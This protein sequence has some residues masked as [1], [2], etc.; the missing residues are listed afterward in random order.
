MNFVKILNLPQLG[1]ITNS[2]FLVIARDGFVGGTFKTTLG[3]ILNSITVQSSPTINLYYDSNIPLLSADFKF[4]NTANTPTINLRYDTVLNVLTASINNINTLNTPTVSL[5]YDTVLNSLTAAL[6]PPISIQ[7][8]GTGITTSPNA[9]TLLIGNGA[10]YTLY[11][12]SDG[13]KIAGSNFQVAIEPGGGLGFNSNGE[14]KIEDKVTFIDSNTEIKIYIPTNT[15]MTTVPAGNVSPNTP[16]KYVTDSL[17]TGLTAM[18]LPYY[19]NSVVLVN[20]RIKN[21]LVPGT[22]FFWSWP[23]AAPTAPATK[24]VNILF[25]NETGSTDNVGADSNYFSGVI[26]PFNPDSLSTLRHRNDIVNTRNAL[27]NSN[28]R[29]VIIQLKNNYG[30]SSATAASNGVKTRDYLYTVIEGLGAYAGSIGLSQYKSNIGV[31]YDVEPT[32]SPS[33]IA[34]KVFNA[35][36]TL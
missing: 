29:L 24:L 34:D 23:A 4:L 25:I 13:L 9:G 20:E 18:L 30:N 7:N 36:I 28:V 5:T 6:N 26:Y 14:L 35:L 27:N 21:I 32:F 31:Q 22:Q 3:N 10:N 17:N 15:S 11:N 19:G 33:Y 12:Y 2:D 16:L 8:G 1:T